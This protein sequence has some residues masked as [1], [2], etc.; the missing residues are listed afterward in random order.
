VQLGLP[1][2]SDLWP[3]LF[4]I[5]IN[6]LRICDVS[7]HSNWLI[8]AGDI[9]IDRALSSP[10]DCVV[11]QSDIDCVF[12]RYPVNFMKPNMIKITLQ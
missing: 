9:K 2:E 1:K 8:F 7:I 12:K 11:L 3:M 5:F 6:D 10:S 4:N